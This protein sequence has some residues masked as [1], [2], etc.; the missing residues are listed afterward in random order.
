MV[1]L[2]CYNSLLFFIFKFLYT[3]R[4]LGLFGFS[5]FYNLAIGSKLGKLFFASFGFFFY[6]HA[7]KKIISLCTCRLAFSW[8]DC[9]SLVLVGLKMPLSS[10][11]VSIVVV[12][13]MVG[14]HL[15]I[16]KSSSFLSSNSFANPSCILNCFDNSS[17]YT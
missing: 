15:S 8:F 9:V 10:V 13:Q 16:Y 5:F 14:L 7:S 2:S 11:W 6:Q 12:L 4:L 3:I 1:L 17:I